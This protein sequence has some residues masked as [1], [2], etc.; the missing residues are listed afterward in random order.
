MRMLFSSLCLLF[1]L[2]AFA[3]TP[4]LAHCSAHKGKV[5]TDF[6]TPPPVAAPAKQDGT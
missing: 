2:G 3:A 6:E 5:A 1:A 4:A